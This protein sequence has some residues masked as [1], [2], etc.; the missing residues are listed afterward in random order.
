LR[1]K[2]L[3]PLVYSLSPMSVFVMRAVS[4]VLVIMLLKIS[5]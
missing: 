1:R 4:P 5:N 3:F 2:I